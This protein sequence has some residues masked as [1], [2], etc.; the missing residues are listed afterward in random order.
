MIF[1]VRA[2]TG[3][4]GGKIFGDVKL[5]PSRSHLLVPCLCANWE[6]ASNRRLLIVE[7]ST[8]NVIEA[9]IPVGKFELDMGAGNE[10]LCYWTDDNSIVGSLTYYPPEAAHQFER[11]FL[12]YDLAN[13][14]S[15]S[16]LDLGV[17]RPCWFR[18]PDQFTA[19]Y[20]ADDEP[21]IEWRVRVFANGKSRMAS[22]QEVD[23]YRSLQLEE[24]TQD[25]I[26]ITVSQVDHRASDIR[27]AGKWV[28]RSEGVIE[29]QP[30][31][32]E[33]LRLFVWEEYGDS[34]S[35]TFCF[36]VNGHYR[37]MYS[38]RYVG[39]IPRLEREAA[40]AP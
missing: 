10:S 40:A 1:D 4:T 30:R 19:M 2:H 12:L 38:G 39:K 36:D 14:N 6:P 35:K 16:A 31:W 34:S 9:P 24:D 26:P 32:D 17:T 13:L 37:L 18:F 29:R 25:P 21:V 8:G 5:S 33:E 28:R 3:L 27:A 7:L 23:T 11:K 15:P 22:E 20:L